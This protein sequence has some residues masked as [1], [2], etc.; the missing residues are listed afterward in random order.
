MRQEFSHYARGS[1]WLA[2]L[3]CW[4]WGHVMFPWPFKYYS[5]TY[6]HCVSCRAI[7]MIDSPHWEVK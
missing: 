2:R 1:F 4:S 3:M 6:N 5:W 7:I